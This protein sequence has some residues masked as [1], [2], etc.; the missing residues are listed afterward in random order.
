MTQARRERGRKQ[1]AEEVRSMRE[2][3]KDEDM[4]T[5]KTKLKVH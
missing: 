3:G 1:E 5:R 4:R 2:T